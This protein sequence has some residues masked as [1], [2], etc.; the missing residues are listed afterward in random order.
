MAADLKMKAKV[1]LRSGSLD[2]VRDYFDKPV[3]PA[4]KVYGWHGLPIHY[5][6]GTS[7]TRLIY[8]ILLKQGRKGEYAV[9]RE[10][11][12]DPGSVRT[13]LDIGANIGIS[14]VYLA[15]IFPNAEV[16]AFE[17]EPG[18][19]ELL[20]AN[21]KAVPRIKVHPFA[22]GAED[23]ELTLF[24]SDEAVNF[25]GFS[26]HD[27]G[28]ESARS[29]RVPVRHAGRCLAELGLARVDVVKVDTEGS[30]W[31][32]LTAMGEPVLRNIR[33]IMGELH[34]IRDFELLAFLEPMFDIEMKKQLRNRLFNFYAVRRTS[35]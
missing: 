1:W 20:S 11:G 27:L 4:R 21:A 14:T 32:I 18:N 5:R 30:E 28:V 2:F 26:A 25:G 3:Q 12:L 23:G 15:S 22:L 35:S 34:G 9:P 10:S 8:S 7:D 33:L 17:P 13:V 31:D 24:H 16:H 19:C 29:Q 6:S